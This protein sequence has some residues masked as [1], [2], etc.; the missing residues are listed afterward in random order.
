[1]KRKSKHFR[2]FVS[3]T[4]ISDELFVHSICEVTNDLLTDGGMRRLIFV[5][6]Q[7]RRVSRTP[8]HTHTAKP[9]GLG[10]HESIEIKFVVSN[11]ASCL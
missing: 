2:N 3:A 10:L 7:R 8:L 1:M 9:A 4:L 5:N 11:L 6:F